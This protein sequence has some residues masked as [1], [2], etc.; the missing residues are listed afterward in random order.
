MTTPYKPFQLQARWRNQPDDP[1]DYIR[2]FATLQQAEKE[3]QHPSRHSSALQY[4]IVEQFSN[5]EEV[6]RE[7][8]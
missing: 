2:S 7:Y 5:G 4:R 1:F 3:A 6:V 8:P